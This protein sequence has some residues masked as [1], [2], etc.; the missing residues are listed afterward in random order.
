MY[1]PLSS[2]ELISL[3]N[4]PISSDSKYHLLE[5]GDTVSLLDDPDDGDIPVATSASKEAG[6]RENTV[7]R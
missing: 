1:H 5:E 3:F 4:N 7:A 2:V 6:R